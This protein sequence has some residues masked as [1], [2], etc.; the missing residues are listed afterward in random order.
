MSYDTSFH[1]LK[2]TIDISTLSTFNSVLFS[3]NTTLSGANSH[4]NLMVVSCFGS[5]EI[6]LR[7][8]TR[9]AKFTAP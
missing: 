4:L 7:E 8:I 2:S 9:A 5:Q 1:V 3:L 6:L